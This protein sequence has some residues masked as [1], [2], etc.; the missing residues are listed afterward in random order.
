MLETP[1]HLNWKLSGRVELLPF[2][3]A[4]VREK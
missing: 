4:R 1:R 2:Y 3:L